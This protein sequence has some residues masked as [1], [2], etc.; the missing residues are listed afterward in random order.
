MYEQVQPYKI[1]IIKSKIPALVF[2]SQ[3]PLF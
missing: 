1:Y 3:Q 2:N